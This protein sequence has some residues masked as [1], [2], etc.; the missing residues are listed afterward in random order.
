[1]VLSTHHR[2]LS[3]SLTGKHTRCY[4]MLADVK[5][6]KNGL[7]L[8]LQVMEK[9]ES[10]RWIVFVKKIHKLKFSQDACRLLFGAPG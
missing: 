10:E 6:I 2:S 5:G 8:P 4:N 7:N 3:L 9:V 1:M